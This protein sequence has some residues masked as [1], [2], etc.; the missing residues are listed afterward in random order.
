MST[1]LGSDPIKDQEPAV[2]GA[3][4]TLR[5]DRIAAGGDGVGREESGRVVFVP[6]TAPGDVVRVEIV[7]AKPRWAR[8]RVREYVD[9]GDG[10]RQA[11]C[12]VY[13]ECGG[14]RLQHL[15]PAEQR[16]SKRDLV[17]S[18][19]RRIG[20]LDVEVPDP[21]SSGNEF[22]YRNRVTFSSGLSDGT[23]VAGFR[24]IY[25]PGALA[26]VRQCLLAEDP[27][28]EAWDGMR[29]AW[30][31]GI[32][33]PPVGPDTRIT[34]RSAIDGAVD[35][36]VRGGRPTGAEAL[37]DLM[38]EVPGIVGWH[39]GGS[40]DVPR[41]LAGEDTLADRWQGTAFDLPADVF[42]QVNR[43]VSASLDGWLDVRAG[44]VGGL[45][46][47]DLYSGVGARAIRWANEGAHVTACEVDERAVGACRKAAGGSS[48][49]LA[50]IADR[51]ENRIAELL[52]VDLVVVNP[53]RAGL[54][55][56]V[57]EELAT[58]SAER[59]AYVSCDPA[60]LARDLGR[61]QPGWSVDEVQPFDA[62]PQ[63][64][65][66]ETVAWLNRC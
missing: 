21:I 39:H 53:P 60:T 48:G 54:S 28:V 7:E 65:H 55:R 20:S 17:E 47:L 31:G 23:L 30:A 34:V 6:R 58:G 42:L 14:C 22:A 25:D 45:R 56:K 38:E 50:V 51:V 35:V 27:I 4:A 24:T 41:C 36:L 12:P 59:L 63:T 33:E 57:S 64:A 5:V 19:L 32:C 29:R 13:G 26:D 43:E 49:R 18:A 52:P 3:F 8:G 40:R 37:R 62:F 10:R 44:D 11:L 9:R 15:T 61:L 16:R 66:V 1:G 46:I 2:V